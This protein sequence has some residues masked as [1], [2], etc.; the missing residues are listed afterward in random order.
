MSK[1]SLQNLLDSPDVSP[2]ST[3]KRVQPSTELKLDLWG[4]RQGESLLQESSKL[5]QLKLNGAEIAD[6]YGLAFLPSLE[7]HE[8]F[9]H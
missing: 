8:H 4:L 2:E 5:Q 1:Q 9:K 6:L 3:P 7:F